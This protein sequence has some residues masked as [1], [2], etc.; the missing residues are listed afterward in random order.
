MKPISEQQKIIDA[1]TPGP[2][3]AATEIGTGKTDISAIRSGNVGEVVFTLRERGEKVRADAHF[4]AEART[5]YP[6]VLKWVMEARQLME[7][8]IEY[9]R[10][11]FRQWSPGECATDCECYVCEM[12]RVIAKLPA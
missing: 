11:V 4:A 7:A 3:M 2:W 6:A 5:E 9:N 1:A 8:A 12:E 10:D